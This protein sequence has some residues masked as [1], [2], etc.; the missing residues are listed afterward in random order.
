MDPGALRRLLLAVGA[1]CLIHASLLYTVRVSPALPRPAAAPLQARLDV[2]PR[3]LTA[4]QAQR[5]AQSPAA[6]S[7]R[8]RVQ[9]VPPQQAGAAARAATSPAATVTA[10]AVPVPP[11]PAASEG[12][13]QRASYAPP[14]SA[15]APFVRDTTWY[16]ARQLD[17]FPRAVA[18][19]QPVYPAE[20]GSAS[21]EVTLLVMVDDDG[22]VHAVSVAE[23]QP[24]GVFDGAATRAFDGLR[25]QPAMKDGRAVRSRILVRVS[26][27]PEPRE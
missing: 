4:V 11:V 21:G 12:A 7:Q 13:L 1:S 10:A 2:A 14:V 24:P 17:V 25:F 20:A 23:S 22:T 27:S 16:P 9:R 3:E 6:P 19:P 26:F 18:A 15:P 5:R 8:E